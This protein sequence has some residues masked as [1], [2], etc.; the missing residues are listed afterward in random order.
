MTTLEDQLKQEQ[1]ARLRGDMGPAGLYTDPFTP[2]IDVPLAKPDPAPSV[3]GETGVTADPPA[4]AAPPVPRPNA[5]PPKTPAEID[6]ELGLTPGETGL[7]AWPAEDGGFWD[8]AGAAWQKGTLNETFEKARGDYS[9]ALVEEMYG[10]L[11]PTE[12]AALDQRRPRGGKGG[13]MPWQTFMT[14]VLKSASGAAARSPD[15]AA[16]WARYPLTPEAFGQRIIADMQAEDDA[17]QAILDQPNGG[18]AEFLGGAA[19]SMT[20]PEN[21][22]LTFMGGGSGNVARMVLTEAFLNGSAEAI[23]LPGEFRAAEAL[24]NP[25]PNAVQRI[26]LGAALGGGFA[27][28]VAGVAKGARALQA[29]AEAR[30]ASLNETIPPGVDRMDHEAG[31][32]AAEAALRGD[33][34]VKERLKGGARAEVAPAPGTMGDILDEPATLNLPEADLP[35]NEAAVLRSIIGVESGGVANAQNPNSSARGLGQFIS[36]T[37]LTMI[38]KYR[39]DLMEGRTPGQILALRDDPTL[40]AEMTAMYTRENYAHL[41][42]RGLPTTPGELYLAHF[43]G[44]GGAVKA[45]TVTPDTPISSIMSADAIAA[46]AGIRFNGKSFRNFTAG[47]LRAWARRKMQAAYDPNASTDMPTFEATSRGFTGQGQVA[48]GDD[49]RI[50]VDY[51]V[52]DYRSLIRASGDL[53]PR[54]RSRINSDEWVA[55]TAARLDP[56]QLMPSPTA[57]R[58]TPI[59]G[60]D[61]VIE[62]G[63]G[64]S[65]A[66]ARA[67]E[68]HPDRAQA[69]RGAIEAAG[70]Q[71]PEGVDQPVLIARRR[72]ELT[73]DQRRQMVV[74]AQDSGVAQMT[75]T[76]VARA[77]ARNLQAPIL[78][79][80]DPS[81][82]LASDANGGFVRAALATL[83]RSA[84]NAMFDPGG[85]L[86]ALGQR[87]LKE[88][89][90]ARAWPDADILARYT[91]GAPAELKSL[92]EALETAAP[93]QAAL[94]ADI[95]AGLVTP[96]MD[97]SGYVLDAMRLI[98]AARELAARQGMPIAKAVAELVDEVDLLQGAISPLTAALVR[99]MWQGKRAAPADEIAAFLTRYADEAR[100]AGKAGGMFDAPTPRDVLRTIDPDTFGDLPEDFGQARGFATRASSEA[101]P[102]AVA[103][104][105]GEDFDQGAASPAAEA[106]HAEIEAELRGPAQ[107]QTIEARLQAD[108]AYVAAI[109]RQAQIPPTTDLPGYGTDAFW[110]QRRYI[111][112]DG[113]EIAGLPAAVDHLTQVSR[114]LAWSEDGLPPGTIRR[115]REAVILI[116]AP[117]AGKSS[118]ANPLAR[119]RGAAILDADEAKKL[120]P[121]Y[122]KGE[123]SNAVHAESGELAKQALRRLIRDGDNLVLPKVG[124]N[125]ASIDGLIS[126]LKD[127]GYRVDLVEVVVPEAV[128]MDRMMTR[129]DKTGR[130]IPA[131]VMADGIDG[132]PKTYQLL[133]EKGAADGYARID[134]TPDRGEPRGILEDD[135]EILH[136]FGR[137]D[138]RDRN[139]PAGGAARGPDQGRGDQGQAGD[140]T[141]DPPAT[142]AGQ[143]VATGTPA[144]IVPAATP[145]MPLSRP[146]G[147]ALAPIDM[148]ALAIDRA[149]SDLGEFAAIDID[150]PDGTTVRA[151]DILD[152]ID[153]DRSADAVLQACGITQGGAQ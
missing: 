111:A 51:E 101:P 110:Q 135:D 122:G 114:A 47:D 149:R 49:T 86:N 13:V 103:D 37:W 126:G 96:E 91:E 7:P 148:D 95:E 35:Y 145:D 62:S 70:Y 48:V 43:M 94:R 130:F 15:D 22:A 34:T 153:A 54:D 73:P 139:A 108:P 64:R 131:E 45:L 74:D 18:W 132:A 12:Q 38:E 88:A 14:E 39:P 105:Q 121:E 141:P 89:L 136:A 134:N 20:T 115:D 98:G 19:R 31:V 21:I 42:D 71:I 144:A 116:G 80:L 75:P 52:V 61:N 146:A 118:I 68:R 63:N 120:I 104:R 27:G 112:H 26:A 100:T 56:A 127:A 59:V 25:D 3:V 4:P 6:A 57:D 32:E 150:L 9:R 16:R 117:A 67:Y 10:L 33:Q 28:A 119:S 53:Q 140:L 30:R 17:A 143:G 50:E 90:F 107:T 128:A 24:S 106:V 2:G 85:A 109:E 1:R 23:S 138:A 11:S 46:N 151:G 36:K 41:R 92:I 44:P 40:N 55:A 152:D 137:R 113:T 97:I 99:K 125:A 77:T 133:K 76:E 72:T 5:P 65:M 8:V 29:R 84:R 142:G 78:S 66:I 69:Y 129:G 87:Q 58:G 93:A 123:G 79:R 81:A 147:E 82:P 102:E 60:P 124:G 83:P